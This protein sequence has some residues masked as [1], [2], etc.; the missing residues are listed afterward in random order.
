LPQLQFQPLKLL[1]FLLAFMNS[2]GFFVLHTR[3]QLLYLC[4]W[5]KQRDTMSLWAVAW[6]HP[7]QPSPQPVGATI[8]L[9]TLITTGRRQGYHHREEQGD[10]REV[11]PQGGGKGITTGRRQGYHHREEAGGGGVNVPLL[12]PLWA[13][14]RALWFYDWAVFPSPHVLPVPSYHF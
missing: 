12:P 2:L 10:H 13:L 14:R 3:L 1:F 8:G 4:T 9:P 6:P 11:S 5:V 7:L